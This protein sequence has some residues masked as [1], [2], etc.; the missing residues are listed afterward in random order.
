MRCLD[1]VFLRGAMAVVLMAFGGT[2]A[3]LLPQAAPQAC[4]AKAVAPI[5]MPVASV[6]MP[7][8]L[9]AQ[10]VVAPTRRPLC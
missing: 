8:A 5:A 1:H 4:A 3:L 7:R 2:G 6:D 10:P 9:L